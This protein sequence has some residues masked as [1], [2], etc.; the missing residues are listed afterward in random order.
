MPSEI[1]A[2]WASD[3]DLI[4]NGGDVVKEGRDLAILQPLDDKFEHA[5]R[6][7]RRCD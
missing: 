3:L 5:G 4:A 2:D 7:G 6:F 1:A